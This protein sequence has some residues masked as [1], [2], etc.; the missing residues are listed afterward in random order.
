[1]ADDAEVKLGADVSDLKSNTADGASSVEESLKKIQSSLDGLSAK[2]KKTGDDVKTHTEGMAAAFAALHE[3]I[4]VRFGSIN[5]V[6]EQFSS[7]L[8]V[9]GALFAGGALFK[10][11]V[12][13]LLSLEDSVRGLVITFG[14]TTEK[15][16]QT[17]IALKLAGLSAETYEQMGQRVGRV[18]RTQS[19]EFDRLG[20]KTKDA[21]GNL[22]PMEQILQNVYTRMQDFKA[23]TDQTEFALSTVGRNAKDFAS[24][25][26]RL[27]SSAD[28][29]AMLMS[30]LN[31]QMGPDKIRQVEQYRQDLNA[32][33]IVLESI[34]EEIGS[35]VLPRLESMTSWFN[36]YGPKAIG[37]IVDAVK[38][39]MSVLT[40]LG[41]LIGSIA[42]YAGSRFENI[43]T[44]ATAAWQA[45]KAAAAFN[46]TEV[47]R[48]I[49]ASDAKIE[50]NNKAAAES[51]AAS[52]R[53]AYDK[54]KALWSDAPSKFGMGDRGIGSSGGLPGSGNQRFTPKPTGGG[55]D[56]RLA[57]WKDELRQ[58]QEAEGYFH[59]FSKAQEAEFWAAK[60]ALVRTN[61]AADVALRRELGHIIFDDR[62]AAAQQEL[63]NDLAKW[64]TMITA[65]QNDKEKQISI[66]VARTATMKAIFGEESKEYQAALNE[67]LKIRDDWVKKE[68]A[69]MKVRT[70]MIEDAATAEVA[71]EEENLN[72]QVALREVSTQQK[73]ATEQQFE[74]RLYALKL[75]ALQQEKAALEAGTIAYVQVEAKIEALEQA[76]QLK[77]TTIANQ[78]ELDRKQ[79]AIQA[80]QDVENAFGTF[81]DDLISRN[82]S[83]KQSFQDLVKSITSDL[84]KLASQEIAKQLF[85]AGT[86]GGNFLNNIFGKIF[87]GGAGASGDT[88]A[89]AAHTAA[90]T[91]DTA[92]YTL[93]TPALQLAFTTLTSA[94][95]SAAAALAAVGTSGATQG[96]GGGILSLFGPSSPIP[97]LDV[98]TP[99]VP[100]DTLAVVHKGEAVIPASMNR[101]G[102]SRSS[103]VTQ[104]FYISGNPDSR[105]IDQIHAAAARG[106]SKATRSIM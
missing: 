48:I 24:D 67:E 55:T 69:I 70:K 38:F 82:K 80:A 31:I 85:G 71:I 100:Q 95:G 33:K 1:M 68:Q 63:Q 34:G 45:I 76:H 17:S 43:A 40:G 29:A 16:T 81:I 2:S 14:M 97:F 36:A 9:L 65:A 12:S 72:Q 91:A 13:S 61:G 106:A 5:N 21:S 66:A 4:R 18:L 86:G 90:V 74:N 56:D 41:T 8:A 28:R 78:A 88:A 62:K 22:L 77:L 96:L 103:N 104:H 35:T 32:F 7:K 98:G 79:V 101:P 47:D 39:L 53:E 51:V 75:Q 73:F 44:S 26:E 84:N 25:M 93:G 89:Q 60:L 94:A 10:G 58:M 49:A 52:W 83:L 64:A 50:A 92:A 54:I 30:Q 15:A 27:S 42:I 23:G 57:A 105:T 6:F 99:Y 87:G 102:G 46:F 37:I 19:D 20:V 11:A 59:E 3:N